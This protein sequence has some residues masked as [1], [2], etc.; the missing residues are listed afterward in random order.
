MVYY[1]KDLDILDQ[2][3]GAGIWFVFW[4][5]LSKGIFR[6]FPLKTII[7]WILVWIIKISTRFFYNNVVNKYNIGH[8]T[9]A[10]NP[11]PKIIKD[12]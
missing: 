6:N 11:Y 4:R 1:L 12:N 10:F 3:S 2:L 7:V 5:Y 9:V 8:F